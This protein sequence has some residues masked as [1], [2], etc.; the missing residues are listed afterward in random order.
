M[1]TK[2]NPARWSKINWT[3]LAIA[4]IN[5]AAALGLI[6]QQHLMAVTAI[7]NTGGPLLIMVFRTKFTEPNA[8]V[9][10]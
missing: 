7:V 5:V 1:K 9:G 2:I 6:P 8:E 3:A 10:P 4:L